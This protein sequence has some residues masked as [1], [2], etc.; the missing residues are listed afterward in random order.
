MLGEDPGLARFV[1]AIARRCGGRVFT[2]DIGRLGEYVVADYLEPAGVAGER[3]AR[4]GPRRRGRHRGNRLRPGAGRG[5]R[6][7]RCPRPRPPDRRP[8]GE[9]ARRRPDGR[10]RR[11]VRHGVRRR[12]R[13]GGATTGSAAGWPDRGPTPSPWPAGSRS[14]APC[15]GGAPGGL[16][17]L[18]EDLATGL[19]VIDADTTVASVVRAD[20]GWRVDDRQAPAVVLAMPDP[21]GL[22]AAGRV[23]ALRAAGA[24]RLRADPGAGGHLAGADLG[25]RRDVRQRPPRRCPGS[26]TTAAAAATARPCW[27]RT[28]R[29][30]FAGQHLDDPAAA[31]PELVE[32]LRR[33]LGSPA[34]PSARTSTAGPSPAPPA[35]AP[36]RTR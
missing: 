20:G 18:V 5:G 16:R 1:D 15:G 31:G 2:P 21:A 13:R 25:L 29:P 26:P 33:L 10:P 9:P 30:S 34:S 14:R 12:L 11:L 28:P 8:D 6:P 17:S 36:S 35:D 7:V 22:P 24:R 27:S 19:D 3:P 23:P 32:A 4:A